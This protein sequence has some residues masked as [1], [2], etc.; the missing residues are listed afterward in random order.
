M[1]FGK[2]IRREMHNHANMHYLNYKLLKKLIK[3]INKSTNEKEIENAKKY[4]EEFE[5]VLHYDLKIIEQTFQNLFKE[6]MNIKNEIE[7]NFSV[8]MIDEDMKIQKKNISFDKL[9]NILKEKNVSKEFFDFC[10]QLSLLSN[11]CKIIRTYVIY[12]YIGL[13]KILKKKKKHCIN[14]FQNIGISDII[15]MYSW[16]LSDELPKLISSV[17]IISDEFMQ[18]F[19][20][21]PVTMEKYICPICLCLIHDPVTLNSCFHSFCWRCLATA[22]QKYSID[23]CPSCR[24]K[25][26][27][28]KNSIKIDGIL[29]QFLEKH[30]VNIE[31]NREKEEEENNKIEN[32]FTSEFYYCD[33]NK[34]C[35]LKNINSDNY[36]FYD[37]SIDEKKKKT[38]FK[39]EELS[40]KMKKTNDKIIK[41]SLYNY[42]LV[43]QKRYSSISSNDDNTY[44]EEKENSFI[45]NEKLEGYY[46]I[47]EN[48]INLKYDDDLVDNSENLNKYLSVLNKDDL[49]VIDDKE[50][51]SDYSDEF[52]ND[53]T[54]KIDYNNLKIKNEDNYNIINNVISYTLN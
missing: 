13:I 9:L 16:C 27:Y 47:E 17:N 4:N 49:N 46:F 36:D 1:K 54:H 53:I 41:S 29:S 52:H 35:V 24:T 22:I 19:S 15:S 31:D 21:S 25:I 30:F 26:V 40:K 2:N 28:D 32:N 7:E 43:K 18:K 14:I 45:N 11:K 3:N 20:N 48:S 39:R 51:E 38:D 50:K 33:E 42:D 10:V 37:E 34:T 8:G 6:I 23:S 12:N 5:N 44:L